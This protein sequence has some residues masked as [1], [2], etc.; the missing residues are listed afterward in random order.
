[1]LF[2][3]GIERIYRRVCTSLQLLHDRA[4]GEAKHRADLQSASACDGTYPTRTWGY[5]DVS[6]TATARCGKRGSK[7]K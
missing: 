2:L 6:P 5:S 4:I 7:D 1:M 3:E